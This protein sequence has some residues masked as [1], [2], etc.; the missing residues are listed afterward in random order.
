M[1]I[2]SVHVHAPSSH[3]TSLTKHKFKDKIIKNLKMARADH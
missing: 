2:F 3:W 1:S